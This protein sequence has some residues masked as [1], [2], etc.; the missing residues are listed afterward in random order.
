MNES[1]EPSAPR[2]AENPLLKLVLEMGPLVL[3]FLA[4]SKPDL[5]RTVVGALTGPA[6]TEGPQSG[7]LIATTVFMAAMLVSLIL[8]KVMMGRLPVMPLVSGVVLLIFGG[9][10][11]AFQDDTFIKLKPTIV[12]T[13]FGLILLGGLAF[14]KSLLSYALD[15]V[16]D[17]DT[18]GWKKLTFRWGLFFLF[19]AIVNEVVWRT[20]TSDFWVAFKVWGVMPITMAFALSQT[21]LLLRHGTKEKP[22]E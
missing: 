14:G 10:T 13:L 6:I 12:N 20:Q 8:T 16:F 3:F 21:P 7:I 19:L 2:R 4:N 22:E 17:L 1:T 18:D 9:L 15:S 5:F 11:L